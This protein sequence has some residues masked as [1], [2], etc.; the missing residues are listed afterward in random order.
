M[1]PL[2][3]DSDSKDTRGRDTNEKPRYDQFSLISSYSK[4]KVILEQ[5]LLC[6]SIFV[7]GHEY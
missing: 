5:E 7:Q 4:V 6:R 3:F 1:K 2:I